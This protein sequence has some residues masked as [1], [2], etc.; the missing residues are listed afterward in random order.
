MNAET[1]L[2]LLL[3]LAA[4]SGWLAARIEQRRHASKSLDLPSAYFKG[5]NFLLNEQPDKAIEIFIRVLEVNSET[6]ETHLALGNLFRRRGEVERA[7]RIHQNLI[8]RP[9]LDKEQRSQALLE[10]GQ[11]YFK[12]GL[13]DRAENLFL[14][15]AEIRQHSEQA[16]TLLRHI[17]QQEKE[18]EK[19][20]NVTRKLARV[21][22]RNLDNV[23]AHYYCELAEQM[24][25]K[26]NF[27]I[28]RAYLKQA[29]DSDP[30][31]LRASILLGDI[32][33]EEGNLH[34]AIRAWRQVEQQDAHYLGE[35]AGRIADG[36]RRLHDDQ[37]LYD[38]FHT[39]LQRHGGVAL[40][41]TFADI[42]QARDGAEAAQK[43][44]VDW[45]RRKPSVHGLHRLLSLNVERAKES[46][47]PD[48]LLLRGIIEELRAQHLGYAC[49]QCGFRGKSLHWLCPG[50]N[51]WNTIKP[52]QEY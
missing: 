26:K 2:W 37:G 50:C 40:A 9:T 3:P 14:E 49:N 29:L 24:F 10:L 23:I 22:G 12:A 31:N 46:A 38:Y 47:R 17:Y 18:W 4:A 28:A 20:V 35:V 48:L 45:L 44:V 43:F 30:N 8:A 42:V 33:A 5:L 25:A 19:A 7:I 32:E 13:F 16:L 36:F 34:D 27:V 21:S 41:L 1:L 15:L 39:A 6:V 11:D 51:R 52:V